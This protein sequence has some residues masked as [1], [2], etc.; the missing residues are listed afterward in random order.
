LYEAN[1]QW[2]KLNSLS[3]AISVSEQVCIGWHG[4]GAYYTDKLTFFHGSSVKV[5][6]A[7]YTSGRII[8]EFLRY[9][10]NFSELF[11]MQLNATGQFEL[12][13]RNLRVIFVGCVAQW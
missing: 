1:I 9:D 3:K 8:F 13:L 4:T 2:N 12:V 6:V 7:Y 10:R 11:C 5:W